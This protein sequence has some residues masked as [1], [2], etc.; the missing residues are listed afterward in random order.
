MS[1]RQPLIAALW[2]LCTSPAITAAPSPVA[3]QDA[4]ALLVAAIDAPDGRAQGILS[5]DLAQAITQRFQSRSPI[6]IDVITLKRY[7][8]PGCRRLQVTFW[9]DGVLQPGNTAPRR[10]SVA[11]GINYCRDGQPP[12]SLS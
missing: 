8:Q 3:V 12:R 10:Q 2:M 4:R 7:A 9:Q 5:G 1:H 6:H 11:F